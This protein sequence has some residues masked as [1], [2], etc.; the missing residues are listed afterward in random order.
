LNFNKKL[1]NQTIINLIKIYSALSLAEEISNSKVEIVE[2]EDYKNDFDDYSKKV[3]DFI[4]NDFNTPGFFSII[5]EIVRKFNL[6]AVN[7]KITGELKYFSISILGFFKKYGSLLGLFE[8]PKTSF[9][10]DL[11][12]LILKTK[13]IN[14]E[15]IEKAIIKRDKARKEKNYSLSD[16]IRH[17]LANDGIDLND[18][19]DGSTGWSVRV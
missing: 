8:E 17:T 19:P 18:N 10:L 16:K 14:L 2:F 5:F 3:S 9:L 13:K 15:G 7:K 11:N 6:I 12:L 1:I 4:N